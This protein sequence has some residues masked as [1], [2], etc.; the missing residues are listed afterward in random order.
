MLVITWNINRKRKKMHKVIIFLYHN[1]FD[2]HD[3]VTTNVVLQETGT[4]SSQNVK[5]L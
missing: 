2:V 1:T 5:L 4:V 3:T